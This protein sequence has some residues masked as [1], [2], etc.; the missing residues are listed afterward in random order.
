LAS[1]P[2]TDLQSRLKAIASLAPGQ[3]PFTLFPI[4]NQR[5]WEDD[6]DEAKLAGFAR[7]DYV[8][9][10]EKQEN[11]SYNFSVDLPGTP[12]FGYPICPQFYLSW[13]LERIMKLAGFR[14]E[15]EWLASA[16]IQKLTIKNL[17]AM[18][19]QLPVGGFINGHQLTAGM[20]LPDMSV[21]D[22]LKA[23]KGRFGLAFTYNA[24]SRVCYITQFTAA[25]A[26]GP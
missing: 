18:N 13:V 10:W 19:L 22:F 8:N 24:N 7:Q 21:S 15:S 9:A 16:E 4:R 12:K 26:A 14:I 11:G 17:T 25:I 1:N 2:P 3:F 5:F 6:F 20:F 23:I